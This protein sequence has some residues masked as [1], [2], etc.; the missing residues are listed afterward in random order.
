MLNIPHRRKPRHTS[1]LM[2]AVVL[3]AWSELGPDETQIKCSLAGWRMQ[4]SNRESSAAWAIVR[5][6]MQNF[7]PGLLES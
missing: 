2:A 3:R 4:L 1:E 6:M 7:E 5:W